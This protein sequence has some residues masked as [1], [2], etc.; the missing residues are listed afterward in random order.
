MLSL[1][2]SR[3]TIPQ[4]L[5]LLVQHKTS[6]S[7]NHPRRPTHRTH[8][9][10][11]VPRAASVP[12]PAPSPSSEAQH[13]PTQH[14][15]RHQI[16]S[17][18]GPSAARVEERIHVPSSAEQRVA[19]ASNVWYWNI[20]LLLCAGLHL[21]HFTTHSAVNLILGVLRLVFVA[22]GVFS[23]TMQV[24]LTLKTAFKRLDLDGNIP[25]IPVCPSCFWT[26]HG[27]LAPDATCT[28]C[29]AKLFMDN[30][31]QSANNPQPAKAKWQAPYIFPSQLLVFFCGACG[32]FR[33]S[34]GESFGQLGL[35]CCPCPVLVVSTGGMRCALRVLL[36]D[37]VGLPAPS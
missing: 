37:C 5:F 21:C 6:C 9:L 32:A 22:L 17:T 4:P 11:Y 34:L 27:E 2:I 35:G 23:P 31:T 13:E 19:D 12:S 7:N 10:A 24:P 33:N 26:Y 25:I 18:P 28:R 3:Q 20:I 29:D 16:H 36:S 15:I 8:Q 1:Y 14:Q 30:P